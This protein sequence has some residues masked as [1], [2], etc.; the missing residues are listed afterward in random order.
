MHYFFYTR[1]N[2]DKDIA[3]DLLQELFVKLL[4]KSSSFDSDMKF[5]TW[6]YTLANN[7]CK[8]EYKKRTYHSNRI[9][10]EEYLQLH[11]FFNEVDKHFENNCLAIPSDV[12]DSIF[13][14]FNNLKKERKNVFLKPLIGIAA[15]VILLFC[16]NWF[17]N[18]DKAL[19]EVS[20]AEFI[21]YTTEDEYGLYEEEL[22]KV[23]L[24][25]QTMEFN[26]ET[27]LISKP[28]CDW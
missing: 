6:F 16:F 24:L 9:S 13:K 25:L 22:D 11:S 17:S 5:Y 26:K 1:F 21:A 19:N 27:S 20:N 14:S 3:N 8:N 28:N 4:S 2:S 7:N 12:E 23:T 10:E 15:A 18:G